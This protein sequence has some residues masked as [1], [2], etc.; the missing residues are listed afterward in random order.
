VAERQL[1]EWLG[2]YLKNSEYDQVSLLDPQGATRLLSVPA[3]RSPASAAVLQGLAEVLQ[4][5][6]ITIVD[7]YRHDHDQR[8]YLSVLIPILDASTGN[9]VIAVLSLRVDPE[10]YL[11]PFIMRWPTPSETAETL[12]VRRDGDEVLFLNNL[13]FSKEAALTHRI[14]LVRTDVPA[15]MAVSG[16]TGIVEGLAYR[17]EVPVIADVHPVP[18]S[19]WFLMARMNFSEVYA[20]AREHLGMILG[21][22]TA[23]IF[24]IGAGPGLCLAAAGPG[25]LADAACWGRG[26]AGEPTQGFRG[27]GIQQENS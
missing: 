14:P 1:R 2:Q 3:G 9:R 21:L 23:L 20:P 24:G 16:R 26:V 22:M 12:L 6:R 15:V 8:I 17:G 25:F 4:P 13:K 19:P 5:G 10:K 27:T 18:D 7:L 11:Y